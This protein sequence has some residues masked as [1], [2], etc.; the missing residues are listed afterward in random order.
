MNLIFSN[1]FL[2]YNCLQKKTF[3]NIQ[4]LVLNK[5]NYSWNDICQILVHFPN[6]NQLK[7]CFNLITCFDNISIACLS[8]LKI[9]DIESNPIYDW[10][11]MQ[12]LGEL[13]NLEVLYANEIQLDK[14]EFNDCNYRDKTNFFQNLKV[15]TLNQNNINNVTL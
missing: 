5:M 14:I 10:K 13:P 7:V 4:C 2:T 9:L 12:K 11:N 6:L 1:N 15:L 8:R 3:D